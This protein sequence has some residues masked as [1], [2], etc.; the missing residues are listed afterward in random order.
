MAEKKAK[1]K[2][3]GPRKR[4]KLAGKSTELASKELLDATPPE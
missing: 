2:S 3:T 4:R 1:K